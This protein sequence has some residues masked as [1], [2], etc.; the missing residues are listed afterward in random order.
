MAERFGYWNKILHVDLTNKTTWIEEPGDHFFR[1]MGGGRGLIAHYLLKDVPDGADP[2]GPENV[3]VFAPGVLTGVAVP[4]TGRHSVGAKSPLT[5]NFGEGEAG[6][7][8]GAELKHAGWD[9]IV[10]HGASTT[11]VYLWIKDGA[12]EI[13]DASHL[14]GKVTGDVEEVLLEE[15]GDKQ[16]KVAQIGPAGENLVRYACVA[17]DLNEVAGR[18]GLGAVMGSKKLKAVAVRGSMKVPVADQKALA[19]IAKWVATTLEENHKAYHEFGTGAAMVGKSLEGGLPVSNWRYGEWEKVGEQDAVAV[20]DKVRIDMTACYA[21]SVRCKKVVQIE[22]RAEDAGVTR[23]GVQI[24]H[25]PKGRYRVDPKY[26]GPEYES[27]ASLGPSLEV[28]DLIA[29]CKSNE[30]CNY[31]TMDTISTGATLA[32]AMECYEKGVITDEDTGGIP[33]KFRDAEGVID[34]LQRIAHREGF[35]NVLAEGSQRASEIIGRGSEEFLTTIKGLELAMHDPRHMGFM[36]T[37]YLTAPTGGDHMR[38]HGPR[39]GLRNQIGICHFLAYDDPQTLEI[40]NGVTGWGMTQEEMVETAN[41]GVT[42]ARLFNERQGLG[43]EDDVLPKRFWEDTP[44]LKGLTP[45]D[46]D[47]LVQDY[48]KEVGWNLETGSPTPATI[49]KLELAEYVR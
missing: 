39:N 49:Q 14:W 27:L 5:G 29:V 10:V 48:Y 35:G 41:R 6:G 9:G 37:S 15:L 18:T 28:D 8:W 1:I 20:R 31:L 30:M 26:G 34:W 13:R 42:M 2:L 44:K 4:G 11:P 33:L 3:L 43:R 7:F 32:W 25:D 22:K 24:A 19:G 46:Q 16:I 45:A 21:C 47:E 17:N 36:R 12:V 40:I 23:K 38:Q